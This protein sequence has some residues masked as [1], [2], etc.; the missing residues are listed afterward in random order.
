VA[1]AAA[2]IWAGEP[3]PILDAAAV[4]LAVLKG[5]GEVV[6][7]SVLVVTAGAAMAGAAPGA[8]MAPAEVLM[9]VGVVIGAPGQAGSAQAST[10]PAGTMAPCISVA[11]DGVS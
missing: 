7:I 6:A 5:A 2:E 9:A 8:E 1:K 10:A 3:E 4:I 11:D